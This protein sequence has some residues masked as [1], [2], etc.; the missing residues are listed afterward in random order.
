MYLI[1]FHLIS[2]IDLLLFVTFYIECDVLFWFE[3]CLLLL[4][5]SHHMLICVELLI[6]IVENIPSIEEIETTSF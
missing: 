6:N 5:I 2:F 1:L 3:L 4:S